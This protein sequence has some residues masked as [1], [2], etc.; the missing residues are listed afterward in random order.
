MLLL[1]GR[2]VLSDNAEFLTGIRSS[3]GLPL[4]NDIRKKILL[5]GHLDQVINMQWLSTIA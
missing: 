5:C 2:D 3:E 1:L 4:Q